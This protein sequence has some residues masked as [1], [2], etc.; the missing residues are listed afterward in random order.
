VRKALAATVALAALALP[1]AASAHATLRGTVPAD[2]AVLA[3]APRSVRVV[4]DD[5]V[6]VG[7]RNAAVAN[8]TGASVLAGEPTADLDVL[9][10]PLR[11]GLPRGAYS[12]RWSIVSNDG[13]LE[14]GVLAFAV[15]AGE[16]RPHSILGASVPLT[17]T[18]VVLRSL[19]YLGLL[20]A[21]GVVLFGL[22]VRGPLGDALARPLAQVVFFGLL[23]VFVGGSGIVHTSA[24]GTR[25]ALVVRVALLTALAGGAAAAL[26]PARPVLLVPAAVTAL[27]LLLAPTLA[28]HALDPSQPRLLSVPADALHVVAAATWIGVLVGLGVVVPRTGAPAERRREAWRRGSA[29]AL[30][31]VALLAVSGITRAATELSAVSQAWSTSYGRALL[32]KSA[33]FAGL[34]AAGYVSRLR[35]RVVPIE[36]VLIAAVVVAVAVL[37][38]LR[39]GRDPSYSSSGGATVST[40]RSRWASS[41]TTSRKQGAS[42][43]AARPFGPSCGRLDRDARFTVAIAPAAPITPPRAND[44]S[45]LRRPVS[46]MRRSYSCK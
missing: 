13:H 24:P 12:V 31:A 39:P 23:A 41:P 29:L 1:G 21:G 38:E 18:D 35:R 30:G 34:L 28:G 46:S 17:W 10:I 4:F 42:S 19:Y 2:G 32:V 15:G 16:P 40:S 44:R 5:I 43:N 8:L 26:A 37:T 11:P 6:R 7:S 27:A 45:L 9:T 25:Y 33:L 3:H 20:T 36:L 14:R 22:A